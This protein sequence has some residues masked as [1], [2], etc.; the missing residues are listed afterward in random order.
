LSKSDPSDCRAGCRLGHRSISLS[1]I[2]GASLIPNWPRPA[3]WRHQ[4]ER[5]SV[6]VNRLIQRLSNRAQLF[7]A[8]TRIDRPAMSARPLHAM[9]I[10]AAV[11]LSAIAP[12]PTFAE[13]EETEWDVHEL[14]KQCTYKGSL[15]KVFCLEFVSSVARKVFT[16]ALAR[17]DIKHPPNLITMSIPSACPKSIVSNDAMVEAF[18]DWANQHL[19]KWTESARIGIMQAMSDTW[20]CP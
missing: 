15:D 1:V 11:V 18:N 6:C 8:G 9:L 3:H 14:Y 5:I 17:K 2:C 12:V 4:A 20:P 19:E 13:F 16:N 7:G 10:G